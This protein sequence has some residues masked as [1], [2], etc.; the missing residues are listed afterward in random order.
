MYYDIIK[1]HVV[2]N[3]LKISNQSVICR[4]SYYGSKEIHQSLKKRGRNQ[5]VF[6]KKKSKNLR[7]SPSNKMFKKLF[8]CT[9]S[10][11]FSQNSYMILYF[12]NFST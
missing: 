8:N 1:Q 2:C 4:D 9:T 6:T 5:K 7:Q 10:K 12:E 11:V 3:L